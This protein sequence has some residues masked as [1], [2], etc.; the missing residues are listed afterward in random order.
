[1]KAILKKLVNITSILA[2]ALSLFACKDDVEQ[3]IVD[4]RYNPEDSYTLTA[5]NP[6]SIT[7]EVRSNHPWEIINKGTWNVV[8]PEIGLSDSI[9]L[10]T[11]A[12]EENTELDDRIDT[13]IIKSDYWVGKRV[14]LLQKGT[15]YLHPVQDTI[16][17]ESAISSGQVALESNQ[18]W[19]I[20][21]TSGE[22]WLTL[23]SEAEGSK[24]GS[25]SFEATENKGELRYGLITLYDR[26]DK[27]AD[28]LV[29]SQNG[30]LLNVSETE[31]RAVY[32]EQ[33]ITF[34]VESNS[35]WEL[36]K[37]EYDIWYEVEGEVVNE[38]NKTVSLALKEHSGISIRKS[39]IIIRSVSDEDGIVPVERSLVLKQAY[40]PNPEIKEFDGLFSGGAINS[41]SP[42]FDGG[43]MLIG[44]GQHRLLF[45]DI[46][47][48][49]THV[50]T[51]YFRIKEM[52]SSSFP[53]IFFTF[54]WGPEFR[55]HINAS[56]G[57]TATSYSG[58]A[59]LFEE[60]DNIP[61]DINFPHILG[62]SVSDAGEEF[63]GKTKVEMSLDYG[64]PYKTYII[65]IPAINSI[66]LYIGGN[67]GV[68]VWDWYGYTTNLDW[69]N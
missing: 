21:V 32:P 16:V 41:G 48:F 50:G 27:A 7:F 36:V 67:P 17:I 10:I 43:D 18:D 49:T 38:G 23:T 30:V 25:I 2:L 64:L 11:V 31:I 54:N 14:A 62:I 51:H 60:G 35:R 39:E 59:L 55:N 26:N 58:K 63:A 3:T 9:Y 40:K 12:C 65:D 68:C 66:T 28:T 44:E 56:E 69:N 6:E 15:A 45:N 29:V 52:S 4:L 24:N 47:S 61:I 57:I 8:T 33:L 5:A 37:S 42:I 13:L 53:T 1:M 22:S 34:N 19:S 20:E 46:S